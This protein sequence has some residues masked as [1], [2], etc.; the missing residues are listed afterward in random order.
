MTAIAAEMP[1]VALPDPAGRWP[2]VTITGPSD[3]VVH[4]V[5]LIS[6]LDGEGAELRACPVHEGDFAIV[7][8]TQA[9]SYPAQLAAVVPSPAGDRV[10]RMELSSAND[11]I[12][13]RALIAVMH[14]FGALSVAYDVDPAVVAGLM[15]V[16][17]TERRRADELLALVHGATSTQIC[18]V[19]FGLGAVTLCTPTSGTTI[20]LSRRDSG[21][22]SV[23]V[24][25]GA[26]GARNRADEIV[27]SASALEW[28]VT[29]VRGE[30]I[31]IG[32]RPMDTERS[33]DSD[34][35]TLMMPVHQLDGSVVM[36]PGTVHTGPDQR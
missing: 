25:F 28:D 18:T 20:R 24:D 23:T 34:T 3:A 15:I 22:C 36:L 13:C 4:A 27:E 31:T 5:A 19:E 16:Y 29:L 8:R 30:R 21:R 12:T 14:P 33:P 35:R 9:E 32:G 7:D 11:A 6:G 10:R 26:P 17:V 1:V 2:L